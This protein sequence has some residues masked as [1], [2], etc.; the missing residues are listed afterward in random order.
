M[1]TP[2]A[3]PI[4]QAADLQFGT[5]IPAVGSD[6]SEKQEPDAAILARADLVVADSA[7]QCQARGEINQALKAGQ[8]EQDQVL[9]LDDILTGK[10][11]G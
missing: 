4:L 6:T 7:S 1:A 8:I 11:P 9:A 3:A 5:H 10:A 2:G